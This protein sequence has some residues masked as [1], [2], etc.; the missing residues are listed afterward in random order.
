MVIFMYSLFHCRCSSEEAIGKNCREVPG[1]RTQMYPN[2]CPR[3][4][5]DDDKTDDSY[6]IF[7]YGSNSL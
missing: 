5:C 7:E 4:E 3:I 6:N 1:D 2:C